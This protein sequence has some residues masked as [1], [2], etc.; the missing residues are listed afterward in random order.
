MKK[1]EV[2]TPDP[3]QQ[4][5]HDLSKEI[6][7]WKKDGEVLLAVNINSPLLDRPVSKFLTDCG[8]CDILGTTH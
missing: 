1:K 2:L 3:R 4:W 6:K 7:K 8:L 5:I